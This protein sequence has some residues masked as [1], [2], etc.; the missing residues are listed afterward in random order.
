MDEIDLLS[1]LIEDVTSLILKDMKVLRWSIN[2][3]AASVFKDPDVAKT[4]STIHAKY[5]QKII[6]I[7]TYTAT[8]LSKEEI[9]KI[10]KICVILFFNGNR[11]FSTCWPFLHIY[12]ADFIADPTKNRKI[13]SRQ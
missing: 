6:A 2:V 10:K 5:R 4:S 8:T 3:N 1:G 9:Q 11:L 13:F 7:I 12:E